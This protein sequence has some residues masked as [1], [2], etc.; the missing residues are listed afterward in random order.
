M[1]RA[2]WAL[3]LAGLLAGCA[4]EWRRPGTGAPQRRRDEAR[5]AEYARANALYE[6]RMAFP[7]RVRRRF[8]NFT[9]YEYVYPSRSSAEAKLFVRCMEGKGYRAFEKQAK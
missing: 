4:Y 5:C 8:D 6:I 9:Y 1:R 2:A 3:M 7:R